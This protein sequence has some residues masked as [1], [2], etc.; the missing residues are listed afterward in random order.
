MNLADTA[1]NLWEPYIYVEQHQKINT[2]GRRQRG[3]IIIS[4]FKILRSQT[5]LLKINFGDALHSYIYTKQLQY[6]TSTGYKVSSICYV[7][8]FDIFLGHV[9]C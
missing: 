9:C 4:S 7:N 2:S 8:T 1:H 5:T 6:I 3:E